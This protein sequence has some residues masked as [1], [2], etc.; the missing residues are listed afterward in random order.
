MIYRPGQIVRHETEGDFEI[1][2]V[3]ALESVLYQLRK[4]GRP[5]D[6][7]ERGGLIFKEETVTELFTPVG[8]GQ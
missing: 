2:G 5:G 3:K 8:G 1:I 7:A 6:N 4:V